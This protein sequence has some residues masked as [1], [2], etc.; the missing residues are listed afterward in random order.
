[1]LSFQSESIYKRIQNIIPSTFCITHSFIVQNTQY[2]NNIL[3]K[4]YGTLPTPVH[5]QSCTIMYT[6]IYY[7]Y[8]APLQC[9]TIT[10]CCSINIDSSL[11]FL[12]IHTNGTFSLNLQ[13]LFSLQP[14]HRCLVPCLA[15][16][17]LGRWGHFLVQQKCLGSHGLGFR[18]SWLC[19]ELRRCTHNFTKLHFIWG[20]GQ[21]S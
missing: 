17:L 4:L 10:R 16:W 12:P 11:L 18:A 19:L 15:G 14:H 2:Q 9:I 6:T 8:Y 20:G 13:V 5:I 7:N 1:M 21:K 3:Y